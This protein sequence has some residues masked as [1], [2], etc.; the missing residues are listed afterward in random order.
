M[1]VRFDYGRGSMS[2]NLD[3]L[4]PTTQKKARQLFSLM[5]PNLPEEKLQE[6]ES[7]LIGKTRKGTERDKQR[8]TKYLEI[9][10]RLRK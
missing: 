9:F 4:F 2:V 3:K 5:I 8:F 1:I 6:V 7:W 10:R